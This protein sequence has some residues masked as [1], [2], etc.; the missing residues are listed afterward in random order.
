MACALPSP[1]KTPEW[2]GQGA[3]AHAGLQYKTDI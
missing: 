1:G 2:I 3:V